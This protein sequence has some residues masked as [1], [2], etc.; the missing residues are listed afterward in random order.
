MLNSIIPVAKGKI[1]IGK[2]FMMPR[3]NSTS[4]ASFTT[5]NSPNANLSLTIGFNNL[6]TIH[7]CACQNITFA[8]P[9]MAKTKAAL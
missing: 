4:N 6:T 2:H 9:V 8:I 3:S 7:T 5:I 1:S